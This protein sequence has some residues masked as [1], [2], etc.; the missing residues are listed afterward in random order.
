MSK[1]NNED[2]DQDPAEQTPGKKE[3]TKLRVLIVDD[4]RADRTLCRELI[5][6]VCDCSVVEA[7]TVAEGLELYKA[8][9]PDLVLLDYYLPGQ[10]GLDF[11][12]SLEL[13]QG[14]PLPVVMLTAEGNEMVAV[15]VMKHGA[16]D[17]MPK[18]ALSTESLRRATDN[19]LTKMKMH[20]RR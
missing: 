9:D 4:N 15:D 12:R 1:A 5:L 13:E 18:S 8:H 16:L 3:H 20:H 17:Y 6:R 10:V 7:N 14:L 19:V 2:H 11:L